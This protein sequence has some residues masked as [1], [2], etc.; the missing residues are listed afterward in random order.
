MDLLDEEM[1]RLKDLAA[2]IQNRNKRNDEISE[3]A[4]K[5][6]IISLIVA[7]VG[8]IISLIAILA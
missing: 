5:I 3:R 6:S 7:I 4:F 1:Q 2:P 8:I